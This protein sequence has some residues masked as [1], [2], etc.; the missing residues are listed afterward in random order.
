MSIGTTLTFRLPDGWTVRKV[1]SV[2]A[3]E[4]LPPFRAEPTVKAAR[5]VVQSVMEDPGNA[6]AP[7]WEAGISTQEYE[8]RL[9][10]ADLCWAIRASAGRGRSTILARLAPMKDNS[11]QMVP[12]QVVFPETLFDTEKLELFLK[13][14]N[15]E[16]VEGLFAG[17]L[18]SNDFQL[19]NG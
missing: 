10:R 13:E 6:D 3:R 16:G 5:W 7:L 17:L 8:A 2:M 18:T 12:C 1:A 4:W 15:I 9:E 11:F 19:A 14:R